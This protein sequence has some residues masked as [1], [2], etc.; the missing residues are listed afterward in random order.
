MV[1]VF[2]AVVSPVNSSVDVEFTVDEACPAKA[3][4]DEVVPPL[5]RYCLPVAKE[6]EVTQLVPSH[7]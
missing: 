3:K 2:V 5:P 6:G 7:N 1:F 4:A